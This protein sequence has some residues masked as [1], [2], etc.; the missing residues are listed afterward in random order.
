MELPK[1]AWLKAHMPTDAF[2]KAHFFDLPDYLTYRATGS[3][4]RSYCSLACKCGYVPSEGG[5]DAPFLHS[6]G[7]GEFV[8]EGYARVGGQEGEVRAAGVPTGH[9]LSVKAANE[10]GLLPGTPVGSAVIDA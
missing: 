8:E 6:V 3:R 5:W 1:M 7:L 10:M 9:G 4:V 2:A